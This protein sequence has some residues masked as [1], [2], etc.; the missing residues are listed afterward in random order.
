MTVRGGVPSRFFDIAML[1]SHADKFAEG[2]ESV[3]VCPG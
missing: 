1:F 2:Q 3:R